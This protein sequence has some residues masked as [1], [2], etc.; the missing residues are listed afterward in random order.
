[1]TDAE[2]L[3]AQAA[4]EITYQVM[5][6][7]LSGADLVHNIGLW[8]HSTA[9]SPE[10]IVLCDEIIG[11]VKVL[12]GG[13]KVNDNTIPLT[14]IEKL[15]PASSF[16]Y[17]KHTLEHFR[18]FWVP[19]VFDR[20]FSRKEGA[21]DCEDLLNEKTLKILETHQPKPLE[22]GLIKE[23]KKLEKSWFREAGLEYRYPTRKT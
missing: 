4:A 2:V 3:G 10:L 23:L 13:L 20:S 17:E 22:A 18:N 14:L 15:G 16:I 6:S 19:S 7:A 12:M 21:Q 8:Y 1:M 9:I 5:T 11:M